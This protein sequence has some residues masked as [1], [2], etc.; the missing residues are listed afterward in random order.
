MKN[1]FTT[2]F[3]YFLVVSTFSQSTQSV[4]IIFNGINNKTKNYKIILDGNSFF[5]NK[6]YS[7]NNDNQNTVVINN[8]EPEKHTL[9]VY[10]LANS[11]AKYNRTSKKTLVYSKTFDLREGYDMDITIN[12]NGRVQFSE[13]STSGEVESKDK[14]PMTSSEFTRL[15]QSVKSKW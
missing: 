8:L 10:R 2:I 9:K 5:S 3:C 4:H 11:N 7:S 1:I 15:L 6:N 14:S 12:A 13:N